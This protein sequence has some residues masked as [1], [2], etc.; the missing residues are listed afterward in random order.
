[1]SPMSHTANPHLI[2]ATNFSEACHAAI[3]MVAQ[4]VDSLQA[5]LT[6]LHVHGRGAQ[7]QASRALDSFFAESAHYPHS[8]RQLL[9]GATAAGIAEF[10]SQHPQS[11]LVMPPSVRTYL[12]RPFHSS[13]RTE[14]LRQVTTPMLTM[15]PDTYAVPE[16]P[17]T[18]GR[19]ACW[20]TG[21]ETRL[22]HVREAAS[23]ARQR[24][25][26]LHLLFVLPEVSE[27]LM[28]EALYSERPL[29]EPAAMQRLDDI[30]ARVGD[31]VRVRIQIGTGDTQRTLAKLLRQCRAQTLVVDRDTAVRKRLLRTSFASALRESPCLLICVPP[32]FKQQNDLLPP[33]NAR[34]ALEEKAQRPSLVVARRAI[35]QSRRSWLAADWSSDFVPA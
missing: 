23:L 6:L 21:D 13:L 31:D 5:K 10:C 14:V 17:K 11:M 15:L 22:D 1:M 18:G 9:S 35:A 25:A 34:Q 29:A 16:L 32:R 8:D 19:V 3:P 28:L 26:E 4:W 7:A 24:D 33:P 2:F 12:P 30:A 27:G 20:I